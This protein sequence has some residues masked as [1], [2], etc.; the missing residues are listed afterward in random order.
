MLHMFLSL[1][2]GY[3]IACVP[4]VSPTACS[5]FSRPMSCVVLSLGRH[6]PHSRLLCCCLRCH[7]PHSLLLSRCCLPYTL[8]FSRCRLLPPLLFS[9]CRL[10]LHPL[11]FSRF[12]LLQQLLFSCC[13]LSLSLCRHLPH[14]LL[15]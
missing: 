7:L 2:L 3:T 5:A 1:P 9:R 8:L 10:L 6:L 15:L 12:R 11:L 4:S 14:S 13:C